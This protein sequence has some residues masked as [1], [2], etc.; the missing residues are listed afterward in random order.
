MQFCKRAGENVSVLVDLGHHLH[1][2][3]VEQLIAFLIREKRLGG[4]HFNDSKYADDDLATGSLNPAELFRI[5][6]TLVEAEQR[7]LM[8]LTDIAFMIDE[9]HN[10]KDPME[11]MIESLVNI[12]HALIKALL[13][14]WDALDEA[15]ADAD[16]ILADTIIRDAFL[17]DVRPVIGEFRLQSGLAADPIEGTLAKR[18]K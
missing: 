13:I 12:E 4:F 18:K 6:A 7:G 11:E 8:P 14:D 3:N 16:P 9:S 5:F 10:I 15:R 2:T 1:G 17:S